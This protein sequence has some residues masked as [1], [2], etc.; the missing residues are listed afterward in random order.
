MENRQIALI[1]LIAATI[2]GML[3]NVGLYFMYI[4]TPKEVT[5]LNSVF[6]LVTIV[7]AAVWI[8]S[9]IRAKEIKKNGGPE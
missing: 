5:M 6:I 8:V 9:E 1:N 3:A 7:L 2:C 4:P